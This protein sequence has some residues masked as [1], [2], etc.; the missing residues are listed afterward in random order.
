MWER[1][2][3][4]W[5]TSPY[6]WSLLLIILLLWVFNAQYELYKDKVDEMLELENSK[7]TQIT[8]LEAQATELSIQ[9]TELNNRI[10]ELEEDHRPNLTIEPVILDN[11]V[12][13][14]YR[15]TEFKVDVVINNIGDRPAHQF[16]MYVAATPLDTPDKHNEIKEKILGNPIYPNI[17]Q[18]IQFDYKGNYSLRDDWGI[19]MVCLRMEYS[20]TRE[21]ELYE[22]EETWVAVT[23][24]FD[25]GE[26]WCITPEPE[27]IEQHKI[28]VDKLFQDD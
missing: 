17:K 16:K 13:E 8:V 12:D 20:D 27:W 21:G 14:G 19:V 15:Y 5:T 28:Y 24:R 18:I 9:I 11:I 25:I 2:K 10:E 7:N 1:F 26:F 3:L 23:M 6:R 22:P 4:F